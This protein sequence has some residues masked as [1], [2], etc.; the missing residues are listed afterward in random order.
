VNKGKDT[1][2]VKNYELGVLLGTRDPDIRD[3]WLKRTPHF[4][5]TQGAKRYTPGTSGH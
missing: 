2:D 1:L 4:L 5:P 3:D